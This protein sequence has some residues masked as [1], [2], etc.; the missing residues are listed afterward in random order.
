M[1]QIIQLC[2]PGRRVILSE[3]AFRLNGTLKR[4]P[5]YRC[6]RQSLNFASFAL[7]C[8]ILFGASVLSPTSATAQATPLAS[9]DLAVLER[10]YETAFAE[11]FRDPGNL[12]KSFAFAKIAIKLENFEAAIS[13]LERMLLVNP[14]LPRVRLELGVL[15]Y[16]LGSFQLAKTYL[17]RAIEGDDVPGEVRTRVERFLIEIEN[18]LSQHQ[19][20]GSFYGGVRRQSNAN[21]G[22]SST[23]VL[24][25]GIDAVLGDEFTETID[26]NVFL[27]A[28]ARHIYD[29][30]S[31]SGTTFETG[32]T[33]YASQQRSQHSL[34]LLFLEI[35]SGPRFPLESELARNASTRPFLSLEVVGLADAR[36]MTTYGLGGTIKGDFGQH[37]MGEFSLRHK[38]RRFRD[39]GARPTNSDQNGGESSLRLNTRLALNSDN[40]IDMTVAAKTLTATDHHFANREFSALLGYTLNYEGIRLDNK[41]GP[42]SSSL[43]FERKFID[44]KEF[45]TAVDPTNKRDDHQWRANFLTAVPISKDWS[46]IL[47]L[48]RIIANSSLLNYQYHNNIASLGASFKF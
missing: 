12:D 46:I 10:A 30:Q 22:P 9:G 37:L 48:Q 25:N 24:A 39:S 40:I 45:D 6:K 13:A 23:A 47:N 2:R 8:A 21:A 7:M 14:D 15:Y 29:L 19:V 32:A 20:S 18:R 41:A 44:Y 26:Q 1:A 36:Y 31:Q 4:F 34:D 3:I 5:N 17:L 38:E 28:S 16:R 35:N 43:S 33:A 27:T 42:W 11:V